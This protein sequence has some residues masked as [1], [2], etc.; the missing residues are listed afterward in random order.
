MKRN[1]AIAGVIVIALLLVGGTLLMDRDRDRDARPADTGG[2][3]QTGPVA[4]GRVTTPPTRTVAF[5]DPAN[6][7]EGST[8][9]VEFVPYGTGPAPKT[10][11]IA[12]TSSEPSG[13]VARPFDLAGRSVLAGTSRLPAK[14]AVT[15]GGRYT[16]TIV[17]ARQ[18]DVLVPML[19]RCAA[20]K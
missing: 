8:Y 12:V 17:L 19:I 2:S 14:M 7:S 10:L 6:A 9:T 13:A 5:V 1:W 4:L 15:K 20:A 11:V 3:P 18:G 16:G